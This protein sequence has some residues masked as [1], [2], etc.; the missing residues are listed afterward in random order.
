M[1]KSRYTWVN[2]SLDAN[3]L[4]HKIVKEKNIRI[5]SVCGIPK[6]GLVPAAMIAGLLKIPVT[7]FVGSETLIV[8]DI[9]DS[10]A[11]I[12]QYK[13]RFPNNIYAVL[14]SKKY[15]PKIENVYVATKK[16]AD[17]W[18]EF[19]WEDRT[20]KT[21][22]D[23]ITRQLELI[24]EN[25][26]REGLVET[27]KRVV[28]AYQY[29]FSG[30]KANPQSVFKTFDTDGYS[31]M[32][33][34]KDC[35]IYSCCEHHM[36]PFFG[37]VHVA[38]IPDKKIIGISKLARLVDIFAKRLQIQE[39]LC[40]QVTGALM[41]NL[42]CKGAACVI[43]ANHLCMRM[44]GVEKQ[45]SIMVT[46]SLEGSFLTEPATRTEFFSMIKVGG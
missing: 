1:R 42:S 46:S 39:R 15:S 33:L 8:D 10:G 20:E 34:L 36:L 40:K 14:V 30:Y 45:N 6:G 26:T 22:E 18:V 5:K 27:P 44:R 19:P 29:I 28:S 4:V 9:L 7:D 25:P 43:E 3:N 31:E 32:I 13:Q 12:A 24:G 37:K 38:Y 21:G 23:L 17:C 2:L 16:T 41:S 35:E 11:T